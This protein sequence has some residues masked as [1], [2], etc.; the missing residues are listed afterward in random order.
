MV[1]DSYNSIIQPDDINELYYYPCSLPL[2]IKPFFWMAHVY[3]YTI[4]Q[5]G[6]GGAA[7]PLL[8]EFGLSDAEP[9]GG[10]WDGGAP[11]WCLLA[12]NFFW[13]RQKSHEL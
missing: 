4:L 10:R 9:R 13:N 12:N 2:F 3:P 7:A 8:R 1:D 6:C 11:W 5:V